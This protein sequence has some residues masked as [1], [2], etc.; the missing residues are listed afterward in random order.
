MVY[1]LL[2]LIIVGKPY[3]V[4]EIQFPI[5]CQ[6]KF[7]IDTETSIRNINSLKYI[8]GEI[9]RKKNNFF[10]MLNFNECTRLD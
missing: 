8:N 7:I 3:K 9:T 5:M 2:F 4:L 1:Q 6:D 10:P